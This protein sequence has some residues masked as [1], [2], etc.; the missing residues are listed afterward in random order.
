M[1]NQIEDVKVADRAHD[2]VE[3]F[4]PRSVRPYARLSRLDRPIGT[5]LL[6]LPCWWSLAMATMA[7]GGGV[8]SLWYLLLFAIG[9]T[10]MRGAGC[11]YNDIVDRDF[12]AQVA[13]SRSRP[14][15]SGQV[16]VAQAWAFLV[17]QCLTGLV[18]LLQFNNFA[19]VVGLAS[20]L[21]VA[22]YPFM[23]RI[24]YWPQFVLGLAFNWGALMGWA[25]VMG[26]LSLP[27]FLLYAG[28]ISWT[29]A[30]DTIYAHQDKE[31]DVMI[32]LKSTALKFG[33]TTG[34][35]LTGFFAAAIIFI[36]AAAFTAGAGILF[37]IGLAAAGAHAVWQLRKLEIDNS[38]LCLKLFRSNRDMGL[39]IFAAFAV[40]AML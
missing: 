1:A 9:A 4:L 32:G 34:T 11:T 14:I 26:E 21:I 19:I 35:W 22:A 3:R 29:L 39:I 27:A 2:W 6:L 7:S 13:R 23:K 16:S 20:L 12:D 18:V 5:W 40:D 28:G 8:A 30:Y 15:P 24:T 37:Y 36:A 31:D 10:A 17:A 33:E 38:D 25:V